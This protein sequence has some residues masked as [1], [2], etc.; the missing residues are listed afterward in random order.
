MDA[1]DQPH[2]W[3]RQLAGDAWYQTLEWQHLLMSDPVLCLLIFPS[4]FD[5]NIFRHTWVL[6][7]IGS[8]WPQ[9]QRGTCCK[10]TEINYT[11][12]KFQ[13][14]NH[15]SSFIELLF[16]LLLVLVEDFRTVVE[17]E[18]CDVLCSKQRSVF[19]IWRCEH[20]SHESTSTSSCN[21]IKII[22]QSC[23]FSIQFLH[24]VE[25]ILK[26][27]YVHEA[28]HKPVFI[29]HKERTKKGIPIFTWSSD[30][31][32]LRI[33]AGMIPRIPPPSML[34]MVIKFPSVGG[35]RGDLGVLSISDIEWRRNGR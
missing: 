14:V 28:M 5:V 7:A 13:P 4:R 12:C 30:S 2:R 11:N 32:K 19:L 18:V 9:K 8:D 1:D 20:S 26:H 35:W 25:E 33:V 29:E 3:R 10:I 31:K 23:L 34:R 24:K 6:P 27:V 17:I 21:H 15:L 16:L 22:C